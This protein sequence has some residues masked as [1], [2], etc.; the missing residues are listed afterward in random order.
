MLRF[1]PGAR[2]PAITIDRECSLMCDHCRGTFLDCM[3][4][5]EDPADLL[6]FGMD[7]WEN[8]GV[9]MLISGGF[10]A[11]G[12]LDIGPYL[13]AIGELSDMTDLIINVH[14]GFLARDS[15]EELAAAGVD[16]V[17][18]DLIGDAR[19]IQ[20]LYH[21]DRRPLD[22][23]ETG[24]RAQDAGIEV[25]PHVTMGL[26][27][28]E[29]IGESTAVSMAAQLGAKALIVNALVDGPL[30]GLRSPP[31]ELMSWMREN[32]EGRLVLGCMH[33]RGKGYLEAADEAGFD[34]AVAPGP[35]ALPGCCAMAA[36]DEW[37]EMLR[38][39]A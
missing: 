12:R 17:S 24:R 2:F 4:H 16:I 27:R 34:G 5:I 15:A 1:M 19:T 7:L 20:E 6:S 3:K 9:G 35:D 18:I 36:R 26:H 21:L 30:P 23:M 32:F 25:V 31:V 37:L 10:D 14:S 8:D 13:P 38:K 11:E 28:G 29:I 39:R 22:Y 33:P